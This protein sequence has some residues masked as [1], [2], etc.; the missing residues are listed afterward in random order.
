MR[1]ENLKL[2]IVVWLLTA[3][4]GLAATGSWNGVAFTAWNGVA[5]TAWNGTSISCAGGGGGASF[6]DNFNRTDANPM[7]TT[8]SDGHS[9]TSGPGGLDD[10]IIFGNELKGVSSG[11]SVGWGARVLTPTFANNQRA[12]VTLGTTVGAFYVGPAVRVQ[13]TTDCGGYYLLSEASTTIL[14]IYKVTANG[15]T[16]TQLGA[17]YTVTALVTGDTLTLEVSGTTLT[18][19]KNGSQVST[20]RTDATFSS[21]QPGVYC[22]NS[23]S[24]TTFTAV[25]I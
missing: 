20:T 4:S 5:Q 3:V 17:D 22:E 24:V 14:R 7:S 15:A 16:F 21:G 18:V 9:W 23:A 19:K 10:A 25:D 6:T 12:T 8:A 13:S 1:I 2:I 11:S